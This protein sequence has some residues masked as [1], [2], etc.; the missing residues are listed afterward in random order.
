MKNG[1]IILA[2]GKG[3]RMKSKHPKVLHRIY[4]RPLLSYVLDSLEGLLGNHPIVVIGH[5]GAEIRGAYE[6]RLEFREQEQQLG[7][8]DAVKAALSALTDEEALFV[9]CGDTPLLRRETLQGMARHFEE[10]GYGALVLTAKV[11]DSTGYGRI[12][13]DPNGSLLRIVEEKDATP[14]ERGIQEINSGTYIFRRDL[15]EMALGELR[16]DNAGGEYYLTDTLAVIRE[17]GFTIGVYQTEDPDEILGI[18]DRIQLEAATR[19]IQ[20]RINRKAMAE[21][22]TIED[23]SSTYIGPEV[24]LGQDVIIGPNVF[25]AG[26]TYIADDVQIGP[27]TTIK[28]SII[29]EG[30][31]ILASI[32]MESRLGKGCNIGPFAYIRPGSE[33]GDKVKVGDFVEVKKSKVGVG[34]KIPHHSYIGD[35]VLGSKVNIGA[36]TITCNYDGV[37]KHQTIIEDGAF[38]GSNSNLVAPVTVGKNAYI[39]AG[40]TI[41]TDVP[42]GALGLERSKQQ[43][44]E[45]WKNKKKKN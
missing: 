23:S 28:D 20:G 30:T 31:T 26:K 2:A 38:I 21:G 37:H 1:A 11:E 40:S 9:L 8:G 19:I 12:L 14:E 44:I 43:T 39:G 34:S 7:T 4:G 25:L 32:I 3:T 22:V 16:N 5:G 15:L 13:R 45:N 42:D 17:K 33:L 6:D 27:G 35:S 10:E 36:G 41:T 24:Q 18:N 29:G